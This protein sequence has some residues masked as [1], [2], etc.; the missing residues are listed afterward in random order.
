MCVI[1]GDKFIV[2]TIVT[3]YNGHNLTSAIEKHKS[4]LLG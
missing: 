4:T 2:Q 1:A 3:T